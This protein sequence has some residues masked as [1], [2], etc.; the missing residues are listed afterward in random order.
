[1]KKLLLIV[2]L[3]SIGYSQ[4]LIPVIETYNDGDE[5]KFSSNY[6]I[7]GI[8]FN[9]GN[10]LSVAPNI[11]MTFVEDGTKDSNEYKINFQFIF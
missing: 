7:A 6:L 4:N 2:L 3:L 1:M 9:C 11:R 10:G 5:V 8:L